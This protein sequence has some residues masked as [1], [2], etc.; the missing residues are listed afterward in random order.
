MD[1]GISDRIFAVLKEKGISQ[2]EF[3]RQSGIPESTISDWKK[4]GN[5]PK[6]ESILAICRT[7]DISVY[8]LLSDGTQPVP[9]KEPDYFLSDSEKDL[10]ERYRGLD[11]KQKKTVLTY[12]DKLVNRIS[13]D[14]AAS[15]EKRAAVDAVD[16]H[17]LITSL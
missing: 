17:I 12:F 4:K 11:E 15:D 2:K 7:L 8:D 14:E 16:T 10:I 9:E 6:A 5:T 13:Y 1:T 3:S